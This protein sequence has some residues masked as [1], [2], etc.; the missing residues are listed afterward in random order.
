MGY[1]AGNFNQGTNAIA[2]GY[3]AGNTNQSENSIVI[4]ASGISLPAPTPS[5]FYVNPIRNTTTTDPSYALIY[6]TVTSEIFYSN[7]TFVIDHPKYN[8]K[9]LVHS[10]LEGP[11]AGIYYRGESEITNNEYCEIKL[12][13][14]LSNFG[15]NFTIQITP[16]YSGKQIK[17]LYTS[18]VKNN[19]FTVYGEN[20]E[21]Y[22]LV[23][24]SRNNI[25][26]EPNKNDVSIKG[27]GPYKWF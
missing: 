25:C 20:S 16:I 3:N 17:Q 18:R 10:C 12:P 23:H 8:D 27:F 14:Y 24:A 22:W 7:K 5:A 6:D 2:I 9:Y 21:F 1:N 11:E 13:D 4:N 15:F 19:S 26:V